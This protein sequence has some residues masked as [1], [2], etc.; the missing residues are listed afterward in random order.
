MTDIRLPCIHLAAVFSLSLFGG[1]KVD[2]K[3][4]TG[5]TDAG[6]D[7]MSCK[8]Y[9]KHNQLFLDK[10]GIIYLAPRNERIDGYSY[11]TGGR[12]AQWDVRPSIGH[13]FECKYHQKIVVN[14][15]LWELAQMGF[16]K[17]K[18]I[19]NRGILVCKDIPPQ[20]LEVL[21]TTFMETNARFKRMMNACA[22]SSFWTNTMFLGVHLN[23]GWLSSGKVPFDMTK[24]YER[25]E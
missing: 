6:Q 5:A 25:G 4:I 20:F 13:D 8:W 1:F 23:I 11:P 22:I 17:N 14:L 15:S 12:M 2:E 7:P 9:T 3:F 24:I 16:V 10:D 19:D 21:P 18:C